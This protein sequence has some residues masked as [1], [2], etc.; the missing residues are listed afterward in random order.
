MS[1]RL[2]AAAALVPFALF[3]WYGAYLP[4]IGS[5]FEVTQTIAWVPALNVDLAF[6]LDGFSL[7]FTLLVTGIGTLVVLYANAYFADAPA[8]R[9]AGFIALILM[10]MGAMLG[11][12]WSDNLI[13][14]YVFWELTSLFSY[15]ILSLI[16]I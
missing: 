13:G 11:T 8:P 5:D 7:L 2:G 9:R 16:H 1:A 15:F 10:F 4:G 6:R 14:L 3:V 12:V